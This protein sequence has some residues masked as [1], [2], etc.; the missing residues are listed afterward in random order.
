MPRNGKLEPHSDGV[1]AQERDR[2]VRDRKVDDEPQAQG[3]DRQEHGMKVDGGPLAL[4]H[5]KRVYDGSRV[6]E[7]DDYVGSDCNCHFDGHH[8]HGYA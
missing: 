1:M 7:R 8:Y 6:L 3:R 4:E 5:G 2:Q